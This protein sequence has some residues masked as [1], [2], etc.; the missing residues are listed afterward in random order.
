MRKSG[1]PQV[2]EPC[3]YAT[4]AQEATCQEME[5]AI[6]PCFEQQQPDVDATRQPPHQVSAVVHYHS[7]PT[8]VPKHSVCKAQAAREISMPEPPTF[9]PQW[10]HS[11]SSRAEAHSTPDAA[12]AN[13]RPENTARNAYLEAHEMGTPSPSI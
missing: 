4:L 12:T 2:G 5:L 6:V 13:Q 11:S 10:P 7:L 1:I 3:M 8:L 9:Q